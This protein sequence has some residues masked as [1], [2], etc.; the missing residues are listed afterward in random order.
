M[1]ISFWWRETWRLYLRYLCAG[2]AVIPAGAAYA[3][4][5]QDNLDRPWAIGALLITG[6]ALAALGWASCDRMFAKTKAKVQFVPESDL[7]VAAYGVGMRGAVIALP[8]SRMAISGQLPRDSA[9][10]TNQQ[11][12]DAGVLASEL[13][14]AAR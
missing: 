11:G 6:F 7:N 10:Y 8:F 3:F 1:R 14:A 12:C 5:V 4:L 2:V 13:L 9:P